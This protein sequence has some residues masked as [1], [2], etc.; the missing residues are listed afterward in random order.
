MAELPPVGGIHRVA[1]AIASSGGDSTAS[2]HRY[3]IGVGFMALERQAR[4]K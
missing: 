3:K 2:V 1:D 4:I